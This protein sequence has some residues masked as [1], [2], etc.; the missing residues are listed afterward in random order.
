MLIGDLYLSICRRGRGTSS[1]CDR[2]KV[3]CHTKGRRITEAGS[4]NKAEGQG[5]EGKRRGIEKW[6]R[7]SKERFEQL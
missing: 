2:T 7:Q 1:K 6:S 4:W 5:D 3:E